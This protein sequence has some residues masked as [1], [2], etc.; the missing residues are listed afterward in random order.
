MR[1]ATTDRLEILCVPKHILT[2][3]DLGPDLLEKQYNYRITIR[4]LHAS[5]LQDDLI[6]ALDQ[7]SIR[8]AAAQPPD[9]RWACIFYDTNNTRVLAMYFDGF[10]RKGLINGTPVTSVGPIVEVLERR[11]ASLWG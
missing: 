3:A 9:V 11:C 5:E 8:R 2:R 6:R 7:P 4:M 10:G 1:S